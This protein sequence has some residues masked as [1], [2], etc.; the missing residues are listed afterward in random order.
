MLAQIILVM[1]PY[2][3]HNIPIVTI[4]QSWQIN[5]T[6]RKKMAVLGTWYIPYMYATLQNTMT[7]SPPHTSCMACIDDHTS[8]QLQA[9]TYM[10]CTCTTHICP[11]RVQSSR[12]T[13]QDTLA[14]AIIKGAASWY[15]YACNLTIGWVGSRSDCVHIAKI[16]TLHGCACA[17]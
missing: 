3:C 17:L 2:V 1:N 10:Y 6:T 8:I 13:K 5:T 7:F 11:V 16:S 12:S 4:K 9:N 15:M 14:V